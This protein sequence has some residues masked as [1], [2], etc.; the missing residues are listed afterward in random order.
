MTIFYI[1]LLLFDNIKDEKSY[2]VGEWKNH[3]QE[4]A[5]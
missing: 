3:Q 4:V 1:F 2:F 5:T